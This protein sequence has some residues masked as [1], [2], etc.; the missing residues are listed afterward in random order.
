MDGVLGTLR[1][2]GGSGFTG[3]E[4]SQT[5]VQAGPAG[6]TP[7]GETH[8]SNGLQSALPL[9]SNNRNDRLFHCGCWYLNEVLTTETAVHSE[10]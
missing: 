4:P 3:G 9:K 7:S 6:H 1:S 10:A 8:R 2:H 5:G